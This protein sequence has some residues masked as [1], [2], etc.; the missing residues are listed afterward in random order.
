MKL[1]LF[2]IDGT[3]LSVGGIG[4]RSTKKALETVFGSSGNLDNFYLGGR[5]GKLFFS[6]PWPLQGFKK[7]P[8]MNTGKSS[9]NYC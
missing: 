9:M 4:R 8:I 3:L 1:V 7:T 5:T 2:D 6:E